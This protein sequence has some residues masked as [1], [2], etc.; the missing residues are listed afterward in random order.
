MSSADQRRYAAGRRSRWPREKLTEAV[1][2]LRGLL[3]RETRGRV[4]ASSFIRQYLPLLQFP[5]DV[6]DALSSGQSNLQEAAQLA[7]LTPDRLNCSAQA[8]RT[9]R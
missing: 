3:E 5:S 8:A 4:S 1:S 9:L 7:R 6:A 2:V